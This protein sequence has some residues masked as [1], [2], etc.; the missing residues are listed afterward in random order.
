DLVTTE[1]DRTAFSLLRAAGCRTEDIANAEL[2]EKQMAAGLNCP[3]SSGMGRLFDG[4]AAIL[5]IKT[6]CSYEG[7]GAILLEAA[8]TPCDGVYQYRLEGTP[9]RFD[10]REMIACI[11]EEKKNGVPVGSIAARFHNT[12]LDMA[13]VMCAKTAEETGLHRVVLSGGTF[14][15]QILV[16]HLP[17]LLREKGM[18]VFLHQ[19]VSPNDE[20]LSLGQ[21]MIADALLREQERR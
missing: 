16:R 3:L 15:N 14:Q 20:G 19:R 7:Q 9:L 10:W 2:L 11:V 6:R 12:L 13:A 8:V 17:P 5:G 18:E 1:V 21:L 4:V